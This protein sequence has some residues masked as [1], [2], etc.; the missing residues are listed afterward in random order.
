VEFEG[1]PKIGAALPPEAIHDFELQVVNGESA[2][3]LTYDVLDG[4]NLIGQA[5]YWIE[6]SAFRND[7]SCHALMERGRC[8][9]EGLHLGFDDR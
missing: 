6:T 1:R 8:T 5:E 7:S 3:E 9:A 4:S 2:A